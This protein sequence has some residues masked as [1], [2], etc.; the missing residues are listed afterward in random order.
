LEYS[1]KYAVP[2]FKINVSKSVCAHT[3]PVIKSKTIYL[4]ISKST[5]NPANKKPPVRRQFEPGA[6]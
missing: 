5:H 3:I 4:R 6:G 2:L 1:P